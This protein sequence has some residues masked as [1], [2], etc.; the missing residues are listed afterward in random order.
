M[1]VRKVYISNSILVNMDLG[2]KFDKKKKV[3]ITPFCKDMLE[4]AIGVHKDNIIYLLRSGFS[5]PSGSY[6]RDDQYLRF[7]YFSHVLDEYGLN[8]MLIDINLHKSG[9]ISGNAHI[10]L[11][12]KICYYFV[13]PLVDKNKSAKEMV[14]YIKNK[15]NEYS[16]EELA[17]KAHE[18]K[19]EILLDQETS[20]RE[21]I[22]Q[23]KKNS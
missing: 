18:M 16:V 1:R 6:S 8:N 10:N 23:L 9:K 13:E 20:L 2:I 12:D 7:S 5:G 21:I 14:E 17:L 4:D 11:P 3:E 15:L 22:A 19:L